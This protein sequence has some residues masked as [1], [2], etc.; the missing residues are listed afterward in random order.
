M[1]YFKQ[2]PQMMNIAGHSERDVVLVRFEKKKDHR[3]LQSTSGATAFTFKAG[4]SR[5]KTPDIVVKRVSE[6]VFTVTPEQD[7][8][9][10]EYLLT[11]GLGSSGFDF[12]ITGRK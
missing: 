6:S 4:F 10:G 8:P 2:S 11:F 7:L 12:G 3:E 9:P 1:F 5:E